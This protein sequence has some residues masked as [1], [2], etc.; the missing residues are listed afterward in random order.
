MALPSTQQGAVYGM[1]GAGDKSK[2]LPPP[3]SRV[4]G[5]SRRPSGERE[6]IMK[7]GLFGAT[8]AIW[9]VGLL[10]TFAWTLSDLLA[11]DQDSDT[12][13]VVGIGINGL[14]AL[15]MLLTTWRRYGDLRFALVGTVWLVTA[16]VAIFVNA[17]VPA[18]WTD[19]IS[20]DTDTVTLLMI[21][22]AQVIVGGIAFAVVALS[23]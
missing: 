3:Q 2:R 1:L 23:G 22:L 17:W 13:M 15:G 16:F 14:V 8:I 9:I 4:E 19:I 11:P 21:P 7:L 6:K 10:A 5:G 20:T 12:R 18:A